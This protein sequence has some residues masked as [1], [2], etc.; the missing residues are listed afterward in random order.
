MTDPID[1]RDP[2]RTRPTGTTP[3]RT[4]PSRPDPTR[5]DASRPAPDRNSIDR[6]LADVGVDPAVNSGRSA[7]A[8]ATRP[9]TRL[10]TTPAPASPASAPVPVST[11]VAP[12][13]R[14][15]PAGAGAPVAP[16]TPDDP[17]WSALQARFVDDPGAAVREAGEL[18][19]EA[20][21]HLLHDQGGTPDTEDLRSA[22]LRYRDLHRT[23]APHR[24]GHA[25]SHAR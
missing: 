18:V 3:L 9:A 23:L 12:P 20:V 8:T 22:F 21:R 1:E 10:D 16:S 5:P 17:R 7:T 14:A 25:P 15:V 6:N 4:D 11:T 24:A 13:E 2:S 19:Q